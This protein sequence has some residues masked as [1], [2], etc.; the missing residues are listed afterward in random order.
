MFSQPYREIPQTPVTPVEMTL[1]PNPPSV[2]ST[3]KIG[4][5]PPTARARESYFVEEED[6]RQAPRVPVVL[7][8]QQ[9]DI[10]R[11]PVT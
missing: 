1:Y 5:L 3:P 6:E 8:Y 9:K 7:E 2:E 10:V 11:C 4:W